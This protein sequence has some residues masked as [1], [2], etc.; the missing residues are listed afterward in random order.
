MDFSDTIKD[1]LDYEHS[2]RTYSAHTLDAYFRDLRQF[3][4]FC[5][6]YYPRDDVRLQD[7]DKVSIRHFLGMLTEQGYAPRSAA[8]KLAALKSFFRYALQ[9]KFITKNPAYAIRSPKVPRT[10]PS[11]LSREQTERL[12]RLFEVKDFV[13]ARDSAIIELFYDCGIRLSELLNLR[14]KDVQF[15]RMLIS[16]IGKGDKQRILPLGESSR[17]ALEKYLDYD[18]NDFGKPSREDP[19][20]ISRRGKAISVRNV[21][22]RVEKYLRQVSDGARKNSPHVLRHSFATHMLDEGADLES[23]RMILGRGK[24]FNDPDIYA[25]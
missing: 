21:R 1:F 8:R 14:L 2:V 4:L 7:V 23:V 18:E 16:V 15:R 19:L 10:L 13:T 25:R 22:L 12:F 11:V 24:P 6:D 5:R 3:Y 20:F 17:R 9:Q